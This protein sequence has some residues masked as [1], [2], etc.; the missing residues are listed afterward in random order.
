MHWACQSN[1]IL[2]CVFFV[3]LLKGKKLNTAVNGSITFRKSLT[4]CNRLLPICPRWITNECGALFNSSGSSYTKTVV[5]NIKFAYFITT[6]LNQNIVTNNCSHV[7][8]ASPSNILVYNFY[9]T[10]S[11][12]VSVCVPAISACLLDLTGLLPKP[13]SITLLPPIDEVSD[14]PKAAEKAVADDND[15][16]PPNIDGS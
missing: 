11:T 8:L 6:Q 13:P 15:A 10:W 2:N 16:K 4:N 14:N 1:K 7:I 9:A 5:F 3:N 12:L